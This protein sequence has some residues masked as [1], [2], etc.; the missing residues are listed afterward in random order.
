M[1]FGFEP[2][3]ISTRICKATYG[4]KTNSAFK[5]GT[6]PEEKKT[7]IE[8]DVLCQERFHRHVE[9]HQAVGIDEEFGEKVYVPTW[10]NQT[11]MK[12]EIWTSLYANPRYTDEPGC[13]YHGELNIQMPDTTGGK[14]REIG[15][16]MIFGKTE[17][18]VR[19][20]NKRTDE[21]T[22]AKFD[23]LR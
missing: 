10:S 21:E 23:F 5:E 12:I 19:A 8:G 20:L 6:D 1:L 11:A 16:K 18:Q 7:I 13:S 14:K 4:V 22:N 3:I 2:R 17:L 15:V 9:I